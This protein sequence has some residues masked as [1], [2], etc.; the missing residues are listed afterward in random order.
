VISQIEL[1]GSS[2]SQNGLHVSPPGQSESTVQVVVLLFTQRRTP[3]IVIAA[4]ATRSWLWANP[5]QPV[6]RSGSV[7]DT[8]RP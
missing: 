4:P 1:F 5:F 7:T 6:S 3:A 8:N 2:Q